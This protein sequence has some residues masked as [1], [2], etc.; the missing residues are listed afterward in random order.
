MPIRTLA[1][2]GVDLE[3]VPHRLEKGTSVS[4]NAGPKRGWIVMSHIGWGGEQN[5]IYKVWKPSPNRRVLK[6]ERESSKRT[7]SATS[8]FGSLQDNINQID[9]LKPSP[10][11]SLQDDI[12][13][14]DL[15]KPSP[16]RRVLKL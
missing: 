4:E 10:N 5:T 9:L 8:R 14:I 7:I 1:P 15:L 16:K 2:K 12:N 13:Q 6:P 3:G 11:G